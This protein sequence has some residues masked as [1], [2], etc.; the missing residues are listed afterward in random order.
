MSPGESMIS[1]DLQKCYSEVLK[2]TGRGRWERVFS[3]SFNFNQGF[4]FRKVN[5]ITHVITVTNLGSLKTGTVC[6][7]CRLISHQPIN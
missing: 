3:D 6:Y 7:A 5:L 4:N 1:S 2:W